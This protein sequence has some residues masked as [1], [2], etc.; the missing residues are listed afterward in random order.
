MTHQTHVVAL[1]LF[2]QCRPSII[3]VVNKGEGYPQLLE[4]SQDT[5]FPST[6]RPSMSHSTRR[7]L[8]QFIDCPAVFHFLDVTQS[9]QSLYF[10]NGSNAELIVYSIQFPTFFST[11]ILFFLQ[12]WP[13]VLLSNCVSNLFSIADLFQLRT[14]FKSKKR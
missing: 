10:N 12:I 11:D 4:I 1:G 6:S 5:V 9:F 7:T 3:S 2:N 8:V 14:T 13:A